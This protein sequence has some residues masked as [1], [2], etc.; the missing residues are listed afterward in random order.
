[1][2]ED[3]YSQ[4]ALTTAFYRAYHAKID[5]PKIFD[6]YLAFD[7]VGETEYERIGLEMVAGFR[8]AAPQAAAAFPDQASTLAFMMQ[9]MAPPSLTIS[10]A[11]YTEDCLANAV[12]SGTDQYVILGAGL[13]TFTFRNLNL[14]NDLWVL[15][16]DHPATQEFKKDRLKKLGWQLPAN[17]SFAA[18]DFT[19]ED[20]VS[21]LKRS[22]L[23]KARPSFFNWLGVTYYLPQDVVLST[24]RDIAASSA[25]GSMVVFDY[26]DTDILDPSKVPP[27]VYQVLTLAKQVG[28]PIQGL[29]DASIL[30]EELD[31]LGLDL[32]ENLDAAAIESRFYQERSDSYHACENAHFACAVV[33]EN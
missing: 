9:A 7:L 33:K 19:K 32:Q 20:L 23:D 24:L 1:M 15:E 18:A 3:K 8:A 27:R 31:A 17:T 29:F 4:T 30:A 16:I 25:P 2:R 5:H 28:E 6:D 10:R 12:Y 14:S 11:R 13:D 22:S 26:F 21:V